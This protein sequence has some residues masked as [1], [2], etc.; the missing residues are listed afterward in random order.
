MSYC[1]IYIHLVFSTKDRYPSLTTERREETFAYIGGTLNAIGCKTLIVGGEKDHVHCLFQLSKS[2]SI[3]EVVRLVKA[4]SSKWFTE[5]FGCAFAWQR[6][7][8][9]FSVSKDNVP[10]VVNYISNQEEHH[11]KM[12][13]QEEYIQ[14]LESQGIQYDE[15]FVWQ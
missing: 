4:N 14:F 2:R 1:P 10:R 3:S 12:T 6:Q 11:H 8:S 9:A 7:Y 13:F 15:L 5:H